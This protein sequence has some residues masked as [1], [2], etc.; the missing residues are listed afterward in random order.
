MILN[1]PDATQSYRSHWVHED[2]I[3]FH[4]LCVTL[5]MLKRLREQCPYRGEAIVQG[6]R[7]QQSRGI[8]PRV[9]PKSD[10]DTVQSM[11]R[12]FVP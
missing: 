7:K 12:P 5:T 2:V 1:I 9:F 6:D 8:R 4:S 10:V 3:H 11:K